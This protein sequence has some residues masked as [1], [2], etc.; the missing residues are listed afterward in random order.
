MS[1]SLEAH[2]IAGKRERPEEIVSKL[3]QV[4]VRQ[5]QGMTV[6]DALRQIGVSEHLLSVAQA[7]WRMGHNQLKEL[8]TE[9]Q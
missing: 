4:V 2:R 1:R 3:R 7:L 6:A 8:E 9:K 5:V